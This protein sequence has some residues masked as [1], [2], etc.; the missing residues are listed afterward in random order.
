MEGMHVSFQSS[1]WDGISRWEPSWMG[2]VTLLGSQETQPP[3]SAVLQE[4][5]RAQPG[6]RPWPEPKNP[7]LRLPVSRQWEINPCC[8]QATRSV[9]LCYS[10]QNRLKHYHDT[11]NLSDYLGHNLEF[12]HLWILAREPAIILISSRFTAFKSCVNIPPFF[13]YY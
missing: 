10:S 1:Q 2:L 12:T 11:R 13:Y 8:L 3:A 9:A 4:N 6:R 5:T 7:E